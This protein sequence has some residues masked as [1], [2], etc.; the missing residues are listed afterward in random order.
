MMTVMTVM[1]MVMMVM[2]MMMMMMMMH[3]RRPAAQT[4]PTVSLSETAPRACP[5]RAAGRPV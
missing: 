3:G 5:E 1:I 4:A 2:M